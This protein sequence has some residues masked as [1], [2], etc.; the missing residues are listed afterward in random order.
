MG[1]KLNGMSTSADQMPERVGEG[2]PRSRRG[3]RVFVCTGLVVLLLLLAGMGWRAALIYRHRPATAPDVTL[4]GPPWRIR[5][6]PDGSSVACLCLLRTGNAFGGAV[7]VVDASRNTPLR[8]LARFDAIVWD[9]AWSPDE[10]Q[11]AL[12]T[13][14]G[15][16]EVWDAASNQRV[17]ARQI[18][19]AP[20]RSVAFTK[21]QVAAVAGTGAEPGCGGKLLFLDALTG[22]IRDVKPLHDTPV[23]LVIDRRG[24][25]VFAGNRYG[26]LI[27]VYDLTTHDRID[28]FGWRP[29]VTG[30]PRDAGVAAIALSS[31]GRMLAVAGDEG[32]TIWDV[33][34][35]HQTHE[36][37]LPET[38][39][40]GVEFLP[41]GNS[42]VAT[43]GLWR[44]GSDKFHIA[45]WGITKSALQKHS[46]EMT[47]SVVFALSEGNNVYLALKNGVRQIS[48][49]G[50]ELR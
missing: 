47:E 36:L 32:V 38:S 8:E 13:S 19:D 45:R 22:D 9:I 23:C 26:G 37:K 34:S 3:L 39:F 33:H 40:Y 6:A 7:I 43:F 18:D 29:G 28:Q 10:T 2:A 24:D 30:D 15:R 16:I 27:S 35:H 50:Q 42:F 11:F 49:P 12:C 17:W 4:P 41:D 5:V 21:A 31:D 20:V 46:D 44:K 14:D 48:L 1:G 25:R